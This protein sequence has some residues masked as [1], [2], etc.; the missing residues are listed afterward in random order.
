MTCGTLSTQLRNGLYDNSVG[1]LNH[2]E[3]FRK[4]VLETITEMVHIGTEATRCA[5]QAIGL[6][7]SRV[8]AESTSLEDPDRRERLSTFTTKSIWMALTV[9][10]RRQESFLWRAQS[11]QMN[12]LSPRAPVTILQFKIKTFHRK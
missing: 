11:G 1:C 3:L 2:R 9:R 7:I 5:E 8:M 10:K 12:V 6:Y 4:E